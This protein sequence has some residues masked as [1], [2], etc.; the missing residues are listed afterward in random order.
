MDCIVGGVGLWSAGLTVSDTAESEV[1]VLVPSPYV[2]TILPVMGVAC[3]DGRPISDRYC[4]TR[5]STRDAHAG[6]CECRVS[7]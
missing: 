4:S 5:F 2:T 1:K 3:V 7:S 6:S